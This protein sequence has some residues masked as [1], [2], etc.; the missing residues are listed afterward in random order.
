MVSNLFLGLEEAVV[1]RSKQVLEEHVAG[2]ELCLDEVL[3]E[4]L[5]IP[6]QK[7][8]SGSRACLPLIYNYREGVRK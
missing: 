5:I 2:V 4:G 3:G 8:G 6:V 1:A 7:G